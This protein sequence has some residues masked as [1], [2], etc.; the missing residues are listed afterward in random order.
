[1][2]SAYWPG[3]HRLSAHRM[4]RDESV[5]RDD[6]RDALGIV[7]GSEQIRELDAAAEAG[8]EELA[9]AGF[10]ADEFRSGVDIR[11]EKIVGPSRQLGEIALRRLRRNE[12]RAIVHRPHVNALLRKVNLERVTRIVECNFAVHVGAGQ[13]EHDRLGMRGRIRPLATRCSAILS[14]G[15]LP[16]VAERPFVNPRRA[17][18]SRAAPT[19][20][21][22]CGRCDRR[23]EKK[24][25]GQNVE[26]EASS[27]LHG[28]NPLHNFAAPHKCAMVR[29]AT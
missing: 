21:K 13:I 4:S 28:R 16:T 19:A 22:V 20:L 3:V 27:N 11:F 10:L 18:S 6:S 15:D 26:G 2:S 25:D 8:D 9:A 7:L 14:N 29:L 12:M 17:L 23:D 24:Q 5:E 1:M